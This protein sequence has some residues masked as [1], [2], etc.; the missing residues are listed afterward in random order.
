M[1]PDLSR[2]VKRASE[3]RVAHRRRRLRI[4]ISTGSSDAPTTYFLV[5]DYAEPSGGVRVTYRHVDLLNAHGRSAAVLHQKPGFRCSW[6]DNDTRVVSA[7]DAAVGPED[8][9]VVSE[10]EVDLLAEQTMTVPHAVFNQSGALTWKFGPGAVSAHLRGDSGP[11]AMLTVSQQVARMLTFAF[12]RSDVRIVPPSIDTA[13]FHPGQAAPE[14]VIAYMPRRD[15]PEAQLLW[16]LLA[17]RPALQG[18]RLQAIHGVPQAEVAARLR[19]SSMFVAVSLREGFGLPSAEAMACGAFVVGY[20]AFGGREFFDTE[21]TMPVEPGDV[22]ALAQ[23]IE[24]AVVRENEES[25]W[26]RGRGLAASM[27]IIRAYS[28]EREEQALLRAYADL[29]P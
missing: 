15:A 2:L 17:G 11:L 22:V 4:P 3:A 27:R 13:I 7:A 29:A 16:N 14:R 5:P 9:L 25:G 26:M 1:S 21:D 8:L 6:F 28:R 10:L 18:W 12:P 24:F 23:A 19:K 20:H